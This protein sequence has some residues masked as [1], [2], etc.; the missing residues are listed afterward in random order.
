MRHPWLVVPLLT[1]ACLFS[2]L[3]LAQTSRRVAVVVGVSDY[4][5]KG[6]LFN[7][8][9]DAEQMSATLSRLGYEVALL[10]NPNPDEVLEAISSMGR[11]DTVIDQ[12][13]FFFS[14][15]GLS[16]KGR[17]TLVLGTSDSKKQRLSVMTLPSI[18]D[19]VMQLKPT[20]ALYMLDA[21]RV[22]RGI[23]LPHDGEGLA[24]PPKTA[25]AFF[26]YAAAPGD[27]AYDNSIST[28]SLSPFS[29]ALSDEL[30]VPNQ[31]IGVVMRKVRE[32]VARDTNGKQLPWTE[33]AL[34]GPLVVNEAPT[35]PQLFDLYGRTLKGEASAQRDLGIAYLNG[36]GTP[37]DVERGLALL[38][39][40]AAQKD[41]P[42]LLALGD[43]EAERTGNALQRNSK[44]REWYEKAA[45]AGSA[46]ALYRLAE[47][48]RK[49]LTSDA[50]PPAA[51]LD[52]YRKAAEGGQQDAKTRYLAYA[53]RF[54]FDKKLDRSAIIAALRENA[55]AGNVLA[56]VE[57]GRIYSAPD[58][59]EKD[60][61]EAD[62]WLAQAVR[63]GSTEALLEQSKIYGLGRGRPVDKPKAYE[64]NL[65][66]AKLGN[67]AAMLFVGRML[68][69][70]NGVTADPNA[71]VEW[72]RKSTEAGEGE[73]FA[74]LGYAFEAGIGVDKDVEQAVAI[75]RRGAAL[76]DPVST[77]YLA[78]MYENGLGVRRNMDKAIGYYRR[79]AEL[80]DA[81]AKASI[82]VLANN[83]MLTSNPDA[84]LGAAMLKDVTQKSDDADYI[85][86]LAQMTEKGYGR[87]ANPEEAAKLYKKASDLG[88]AVATDELA[89]LYKMGK[90]VPKDIEKATELWKKAADAG[91]A[92]AYA[93]LAIIYRDRSQSPEDQ[94][95][96]GRWSR[97]GAEAGDSESMVMYGR[98]LFFGKEGF[99]RNAKEGFDWLSK[100]LAA[101]N[102]WAAGSLVTIANDKSLDISPEDREEALMRLVMAANLE[103]NDTAVEALRMIFKAR[104]GID[105]LAPT[106]A[107]LEQALSGSQRGMAAMLLGL[108]YM[109]GRFGGKPDGPKAATYFRMATEAGE[110]Q[111]WR[112]LGDLEAEKMVP[113]ANAQQAFRYY[114]RGAEAGDVAAMN[115]LG[116]AYRKGFGTK[117]DDVK[118]FE[119]FRLASER[120][121]AFAM[122]NLALCYQR[123]VGTPASEEQADL[124]YSRAVNAG[125]LNAAV[126]LVTLLL[127]TEPDNR[128]YTR[129]FYYLNLLARQGRAE[130]FT[131]LEEICRNA[132]L[133][134]PV[135]LR[136]VAIL[137]AVQ[138]NNPQSGAGAVLAR[139]TSTGVITQKAKDYVLKD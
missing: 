135:R 10:R 91:S 28:R 33:D 70:G 17:S 125:N 20:S 82:A 93:N 65:Q 133:P 21:C 53:L 7:P 11:K 89:Y 75:Y 1:I 98:D 118:A 130:A 116:F 3:A 119:Q 137:N 76:S 9:H 123:G 32:R 85:L 66:A 131:S 47:L 57:L 78:V 95:E 41:V 25:G 101:G 63:R 14:G 88:S 111:A 54:G 2:D 62:F 84:A 112:H 134:K 104:E 45:D 51:T 39:Q 73:A 126:G 27:V 129:A 105:I 110:A 50:R 113:G 139:L 127:N 117:V 60:A 42:A 136:A 37:K 35:S 36:Q 31:D 22:S 23:A 74:D 100:G 44:A 61:G 71:A 58:A 87:P 79:A 132:G 99:A 26:A 19:R 12:F 59:P 80:G 96:A 114:Q 92:V 90:G 115:N 56:Q 97:R 107:T 81:R 128:D 108:G 30:L 102:G 49:S 94:A 64:L 46:E 40:A 38:K 29:F 109:D 52:L 122:Y 34:T 67:A 69:Q 138:Q 124:W 77:R 6:N 5:G 18:I 16:V 15:H 121:L 106:Q 8:V 48:V 72:F 4:G 24:P 55:A 13:A 83:G 43:L 120:G 68:Q 103:G 86:K